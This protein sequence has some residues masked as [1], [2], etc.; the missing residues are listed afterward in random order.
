MHPGCD[1]AAGSRLPH[2]AGASAL[3]AGLASGVMLACA[4]AHLLLLAPAGTGERQA[5]VRIPAGSDLRQIARSLAD[6][7]VVA[8]PRLFVLAARIRGLDR[9]LHPGDYRFEPGLSLPGLLSALVEGKG[10]TATVT[11]PEGWRLE[12]IA[13][14]L[15]ASGVCQAGPFLQAARDP[16]LLAEIGIPGPSAEGFLFPET[17]AFALP[18]RGSSSPRRMPSRC[19][20]RRRT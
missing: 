2:G 16:A 19:R 11:V 15:A 18:P 13:E 5:A 4:L 14:R 12:Q 10:R 7:G 9:R 1:A 6:A 8:N 3:F 17:Y 20:R